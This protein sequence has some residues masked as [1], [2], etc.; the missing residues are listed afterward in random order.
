MISII[1]IMNTNHCP[2]LRFKKFSQDSS[3]SFLGKSVRAIALGILTSLSAI[4]PASAQVHRLNSDEMATFQILAANAEQQRIGMRLDPIL[5]KVARQRAA[6]MA[7]RNYFAHVNPD[8]HGANYLVRRAGFTLPAEYN[9]TPS[10]NNIESLAMSTGRPREIANLWLKSPAHRMHILGEIDFYK[11]QT[12]VGVGMFRSSRPP[13]YK[14][15]VFLSA[16]PS[17]IPGARSVRLKDPKGR[18]LTS[19]RKLAA[20][21]ARI[22]GAI[23]R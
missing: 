16:P 15:Y 9:S 20:E 12:A 3:R 19:S 1:K 5:C 10:G 14:Y 2:N 11:R 22:T 21:W 7:R 18:P 23:A 8:G 13:Y 6:D 17:A 4:A